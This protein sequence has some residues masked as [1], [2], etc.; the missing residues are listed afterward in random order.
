MSTIKHNVMR[1]VRAIHFMR[2]FVSTGALA[3]VLVFVS[4]YA[5][6]QEVWVA[7]VFAN[8]PSVTDVAALARFFAAAFM[9]TTFVVQAFSVVAAASAIWLARECTK[10]VLA[11]MR[12][13]LGSA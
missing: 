8:M 9:N 6:S 11:P 3:S 5:I 1:R 13:S 10:L 4:V 2:P 12:A 7:M